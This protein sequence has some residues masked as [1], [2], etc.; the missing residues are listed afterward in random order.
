MRYIYKLIDPVSNDVRY[1][2]QTNDINRRYNDHLSSS[3]REN[4]SQYKTHKSC[5]IRKLISL[6]LRPTIEII[7]E[8]YTL[9]ESNSLEKMYIEKYTLD[10]CRLTNSYVSDVTDFSAETRKK[11]SDFRIGKS[12]EEIYGEEIALELKRKFIDRTSK[13]FS[14]RPKSDIQR[15]KISNTLKEYFTDKENHWAY[16]LK[17]SESHNEK[18]RIAK[19]NNPKN[20][21]NRKPRTEEQKD[22]IRKANIGK[23][24][25]RCPILQLNLDGVIIKEWKSLREI[26]SVLLLKRNQVSKCCKLQ[27]DSYAGFI[28]RYKEV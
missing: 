5:W 21:G 2:G 15:E 4:S 22:N 1:I 3:I 16:G 8:C 27:R 7:Q 10:G 18:L 25:K 24:Q 13:Y 9:S 11:M 20:V 14:N 6:G 23:K 28:W 12:L 17:M 19:L 26:E